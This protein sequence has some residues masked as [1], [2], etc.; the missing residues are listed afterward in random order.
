MWYNN[1]DIKYKNPIIL[2]DLKGYVLPHA[3]TSHTSEILSHTFRFKPSKKFLNK[4]THIYILFFPAS[5]LPNVGKEYHEY[6]TIQKSMDYVLKEFWNIKKNIEYIPINLRDFEIP[7]NLDLTTGLTIISADFSHFLSMQE[8]IPLENCAA[9]SILHRYFSLSC[10]NIIDDKKQF[11]VLYKLIP[12]YWMLQWVG[13]MRSAGLKGVGYLSFL[14]R[15]SYSIPNTFDGIFV[16]VYDKQMRARECL[17]E[18]FTKNNKIT[19]EKIYNKIIEVIKKGKTTSR[20]TNGKFLQ[21]P[22]QN[23]TITFLYKEKTKKFIRG[24][25][26]IKYKAFFLPDVFLENTFNNGIWIKHNDEIWPQEFNF[27]L[28]ETLDKLTNKAYSFNNNLNS[29]DIDYELYSSRVVHGK[30]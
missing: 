2:E 10:A 22:L 30:V 12:E 9:H 18:W 5:N 28:D 16:T 13:R 21:V 20:L 11:E 17:G 8:A 4:M 7:S 27:N 3:G 29:N 24:W 1:R 19:N 23:Y 14:I 6:F 26:G 15:D 25:H